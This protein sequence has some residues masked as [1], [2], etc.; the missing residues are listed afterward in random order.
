M[1]IDSPIIFFDGV[2]NLCNGFV[3]FL[4]RRDTQKKLSFASLQGETARENLPSEK[5]KSLSSVILWDNGVIYEESAAVLRVFFYLG[6]CWKLFLIFHVVPQALRDFVYRWVAKNRYH[7]FG[8]KE[9]CRL[10]TDQE[11]SRFLD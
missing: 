4:I 3:D 11:K 8:Q 10:P 5:I 7:W 9:T 2:C 1:R 6:G